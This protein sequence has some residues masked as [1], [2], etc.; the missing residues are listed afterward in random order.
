MGRKL[1][2]SASLTFSTIIIL[3]GGYNCAGQYEPG[4][5]QPPP[6]PHDPPPDPPDDGPELPEEPP[7]DTCNRRYWRERIKELKAASGFVKIDHSNFE[8]FNFGQPRNFSI[9]CPRLLLNMSRVS[10]SRAYQGKLYLVYERGDSPVGLQYDSGSSAKENK[11]NTWSGSWTGN[12]ATFSAIF[13]HTKKE[14]A[15]ILQIDTVEETDVADGVTSLLGYGDIWF[16]MFRT[17]FHFPYDKGD[18]CLHKGDYVKYA[19]SRPTVP[20]W[21]CWFVPIGPYNCYPR[22]VDTSFRGKRAYSETN[23]NIRTTPTCYKK[24][25]RFLGIDIRKAFNV[26]SGRR[27]P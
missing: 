16:K 12:R 4:P 20:S 3:L 1:F 14:M 23:L 10:G 7:D 26:E 13:E 25:G 19:R 17:A 5:G 15:V 18:V 6:G 24:F 22:G 27:H 8:D 2:I 9:N 11:Y 21:K